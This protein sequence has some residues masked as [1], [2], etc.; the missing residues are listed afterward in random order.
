MWYG[1]L[2]GVSGVSPAKAVV[3]GGGV[4]GTQSAKMLSGLG[5]CDNIR[6][7]PRKTSRVGR[8]HAKKC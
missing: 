7:K 1:L 2:G 8:Y 4:V 5:R 3:I 6:H